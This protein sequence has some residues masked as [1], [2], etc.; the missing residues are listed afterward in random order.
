MACPIAVRCKLFQPAATRFVRQRGFTYMGILVAIA[1]STA[2][3]ASTAEVWHTAQQREKERELIFVGHQFRLAIA[4]YYRASPGTKQYPTKL[5][6]LV[7]DPRQPGT[8]RYLRR[9]W[10]DPITGTPDWG[11]VRGPS[12]EIMGVYSLSEDK[13]LKSANFDQDDAGFEEAKKYSDWIFIYHQRQ[14][15]RRA[16]PMN[17]SAGAEALMPDS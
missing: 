14:P 11:L 8:Q 12:G 17:S 4:R 5:E 9:I 6:D 15:A 3:L 13:P 1:L 16:T 7:K 2:I 10:R